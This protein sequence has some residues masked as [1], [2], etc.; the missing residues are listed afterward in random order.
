MQT[1]TV[2]EWDGVKYTI[3]VNMALINRI[4]NAGV[5][6]MQM[7]IDVAG[8]QIPKFSLIATMY[9]I[10]L[11]SANVDASSDQVWAAIC[12]NK[13]IPIAT[14]ATAAL[15]AFFPDVEIET[16]GSEEKKG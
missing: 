8:G 13:A 2:I 3:P 16:D 6:L 10:M 9:S 4:E 11:K 14:Y 1:E 7:S 15:N 12:K 5:N